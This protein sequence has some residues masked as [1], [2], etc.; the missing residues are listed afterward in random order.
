MLTVEYDTVFIVIYIRRILESPWCV[1]DSDR[2]DSVILSCRMIDTT[3]ISF[4]FRTEKTFRITA[5]PGILGRSDRFRIF[6]RF[7]KINGNIDISVRTFYFPFLVFFYSI[8]ADIVTVLTQFIEIICSLL[9]VFLILIPKF[10][11]NLCRARHQAVH[12]SCI[13]K[14]TVDNAVFC[15]IPLYRFIQKLIQSF[16][17]IYISRFFFR[18]CKFI[19]V[20]NIK[21]KIDRVTA[22]TLRCES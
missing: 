16:F 3:C 6:F 15:Q 2:N 18:L 20:K 19:L 8:T 5:C 10:L 17:Q 1:I 7:G 11:L 12:Q 21:K 22:L 4:V 13:K 14:I 9:R